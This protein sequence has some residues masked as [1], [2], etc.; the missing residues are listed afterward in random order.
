MNV[1]APDSPQLTRIERRIAE[2]LLCAKSSD[3]IARAL[4]RAPRTIRLHFSNMYRKFGLRGNALYVPRL[5][6]ALLIHERHEALGVRC[7]T[8]EYLAAKSE[9]VTSAGELGSL[10]TASESLAH[11]PQ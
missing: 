10:G 4:N 1:N 5:K 8:C 7:Q 11:R 9:V 3:D 6:L 2:L